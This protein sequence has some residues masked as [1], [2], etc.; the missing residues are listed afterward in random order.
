M[1][2][3]DFDMSQL[4]SGLTGEQEENNENRTHTVKRKRA[5]PPPRATSVSR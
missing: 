1:S 5:I 2:K 4:V 3:K